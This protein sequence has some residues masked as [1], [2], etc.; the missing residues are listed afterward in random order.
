M[1]I[2]SNIVVVA[3]AVSSDLGT[4]LWGKIGLTCIRLKSAFAPSNQLKE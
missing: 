1:N 4:G 3:R 2:R